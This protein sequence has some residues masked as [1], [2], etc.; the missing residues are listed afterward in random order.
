MDLPEMSGFESHETRA[1]LGP[2]AHTLADLELGVGNGD[3]TGD[4]AVAGHVIGTFIHGPILAR[5]PELADQLLSWALGTELD[6]L[7]GG[8]AERLRAHRIAEDREDPTGWGGRK[9]GTA[10]TWKTRLRRL[11]GSK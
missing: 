3:G 7:P 10:I 2:D 1:V 6:P 8:T 5:N 4:G 9:Y 11:V